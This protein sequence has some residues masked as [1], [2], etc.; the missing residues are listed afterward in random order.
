MISVEQFEAQSGAD[1]DGGAL[2]LLCLIA[3]GT[4]GYFNG[5][6]SIRVG[7]DPDAK[8]CPLSTIRTRFAFVSEKPHF[9][10]AICLSDIARDKRTNFAKGVDDERTV[11][12]AASPQKSDGKAT[13]RSAAIRAIS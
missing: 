2:N 10:R 3:G 8:R 12:H 7:I 6:N 4:A 5:F 13:P 1:L 9:G 11:R